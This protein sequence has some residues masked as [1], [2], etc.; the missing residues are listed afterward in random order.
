MGREWKKGV[1]NGLEGTP[2]YEVDAHNIVPVWVASEKQEV[3]ARTIRKKIN[4][5]VILI[6]IK[7]PILHPQNETYPTP[8]HPPPPL[9]SPP[10][11][12][13]PYLIE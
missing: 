9:P 7:K 11:P 13:L 6:M 2:V 5:K 12:T 3:G 8:P 10:C 4:D 1:V